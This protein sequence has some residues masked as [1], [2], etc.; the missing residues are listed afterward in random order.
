ME[1]EKGD[2]YKIAFGNVVKQL[3]NWFM[4][5]SFEGESVQDDELG[6]QRVKAY[7][8][9]IHQRS[10]QW[11][12]KAISMAGKRDAA[13]KVL[14]ALL[15]LIAGSKIQLSPLIEPKPASEL[16]TSPEELV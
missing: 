16:P 2:S 9:Y 11:M 13:N 10:S 15:N 12:N 6:T 4:D 5:T 1:Q 14:S 3:N 7:I 8:D